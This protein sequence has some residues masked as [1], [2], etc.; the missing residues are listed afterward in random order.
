MNITLD[1]YYNA[2]GMLS[3]RN[4]E[5]GDKIALTDTDVPSAGI[6]TAS[7]ISYGAQKSLF[8]FAVN[9][10]RNGDNIVAWLPS[11]A[12]VTCEGG[13]IKATVPAQQDGTV[14]PLYIGRA[15][16]SD[17][18]SGVNMSM[19]PLHCIVYGN[20]QLGS[21]SITKAVFT[22]NSGEKVA[23]EVS[24]N[25]SDLSASASEASVTVE[26]AKAVD[27]RTGGFSFPICVAP[28]TLESGYTIRY[29]TDAGEEFE[30]RCDEKTVLEM[31]GKVEVG[32]ASDSQ[33]TQILI[34]GDNMIYHLDAK[35]AIESGYKNA[36]IW[37]WDA[38]NYASV[39]NMEEKNMIRLDDCKLVDDKKKILATSSKSYAV[40]IDRETKEVLWYSTISTNAHSADL[41]PGDR[42]AVACSDNGDCIQIFDLATPN[43]VRFSTELGSAH[44]VVWN[45]YNER[46]YAIGG[47]TLNIYSLQNWETNSPELKLEKSVN[48]SSNVTG[49]HDMTLVDENTLLLAGNKAALY[50]ISQGTFTALSHFNDSN[51][52]KSVNY[53]GD[54]GEC[55]YTDATGSSKSVTWSAENIGFTTD[56][57]KSG[58]ETLIPVEKSF[59][60]YKVRVFHW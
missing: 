36:I 48:T 5:K 33:A 20:V 31:G 45:P 49:L 14:T 34:C 27:C 22:A 54:T 16:F 58:G 59:L 28:V 44:G 11:S 21:Y 23:G 40:L 30:Y 56:V 26:F 29:H 47:K 50:N 38:K 42:V 18:Y 4:W 19:S 8:T 32:S 2:S 13:S 51:A 53:N 7:P 10:A 60:I 3:L 6:T 17:S 37:E 52:L 1:K 55:W 43:V 41:L 9:G 25:P 24:L 12:D 57:N 46:L 15:A 35:I 39:L